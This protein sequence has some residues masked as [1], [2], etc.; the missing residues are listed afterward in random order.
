MGSKNTSALPTLPIRAVRPHRCTKALKQHNT[1]R[2]Y[3]ER[4]GLILNSQTDSKR[5]IL[6]NG[7]CEVLYTFELTQQESLKRNTRDV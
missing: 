7:K 2:A 3:Q 5:A 6:W 1:E 4:L